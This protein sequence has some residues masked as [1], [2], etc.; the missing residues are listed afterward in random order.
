MTQLRDWID[1][2]DPL[3]WPSATSEWAMSKAD[4]LSDTTE[5]H[6]DLALSPTDEDLVRTTFRGRRVLAY[7]CTRLLPREAASILEHEGLRL[8]DDALVRD[9]IAAA[10]ADGDLPTETLAHAQG[11]NIYASGNTA[12]REHQV[13][14]VVGRDVFEEGASGVSPL[15]KHWGGEAIRGGPGEVR[16]LRA[17]GN[18]SIVVVGLALSGKHNAPYAHPPLA[19]VL[20]GRLLGLSGA[21]SSVNYPRPIPAADV[22][23]IWQP[24]DADYDR[25]TRLPAKPPEQGRKHPNDLRAHRPAVTT[26]HVR[27]RG[28]HDL[29]VTLQRRP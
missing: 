21:Y 17:V 27:V 22:A 23:A 9:R 6:T 15:L 13:C 4:Q 10:A 16:A 5:F 28:V 26:H 24:G 8:L 3:T 20:V 11:N 19:T 12:Y 2:D 29:R 7:H 18:P 25:H 1:V 14:V